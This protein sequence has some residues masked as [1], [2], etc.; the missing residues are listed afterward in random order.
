M[1]KKRGRPISVGPTIAVIVRLTAKQLKFVD[2]R[3]RSTEM[4]RNQWIRRVIENALL[5]CL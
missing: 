4:N 5:R 2:D 1:K 3:C